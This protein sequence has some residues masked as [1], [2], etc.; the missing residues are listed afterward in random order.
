MAKFGQLFRTAWEEQRRTRLSAPKQLLVAISEIE[1]ERTSDDHAHVTFRQNHR[2]ERSNLF[3]TKVLDL[4]L[5]GSQWL[6]LQERVV[7]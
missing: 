7:D 6:V 2:T 5:S 1:I 3:A 4:T